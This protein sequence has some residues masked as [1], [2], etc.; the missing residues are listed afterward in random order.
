MIVHDHRIYVEA[1]LNGRGSYLFLFDTGGRF[2]ISRSLAAGLSAPVAGSNAIRGAGGS[3][4]I[5][6]QDVLIRDVG[7]G[8]M[9]M[10]NQRFTVFDFP[11][12]YRYSTPGHPFA[13]MVG[14]EVLSAF[15]VGLHFRSQTLT[16]SPAAPKLPSSTP[17][18]FDN[19]H[20]PLVEA[21]IAGTRSTLLVDTGYPGSALEL[22]D[23]FCEASRARYSLS[24]E[25]YDRRGS[26]TWRVCSRRFSSATVAFGRRRYPHTQC[27]RCLCR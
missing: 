21:T 17:L 25:I 8:S 27:H 26:W 10:A 19:A 5:A 11:N 1:T 2:V 12:S 20:H 16:L 14:K 22:F 9:H 4:A 18:R 3:K 7:F 23:T 15:D 6:S 24:T 13:G